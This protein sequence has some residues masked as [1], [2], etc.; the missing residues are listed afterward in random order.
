MFYNCISLQQLDINTLASVTDNTNIFN[1]TGQFSTL[2]LPQIG[3]T[4]TLAN[5]KLD[6]AGCNQVLTYLR[7]LNGSIAT[8]TLNAGGTGYA[9]GDEVNISAGN[10]DAILKVL[11]I[12][13]GG[14]VTSYLLKVA[15]TGYTVT[16]ALSTSNITG[17][18]SGFKVNVTALVATQTVTLTGNPGAATCTPAIGTAKNWI[19]TI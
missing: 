15:G 18:G 9:V 4:F 5:N 12:G 3:R 19:V 17:T 1:N 13:A 7:D 10:N 14:A 16:N 6:T 11:T 8:S 2:I